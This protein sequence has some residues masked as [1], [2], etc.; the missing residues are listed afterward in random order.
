MG[1]INKAP[2]SQVMVTPEFKVAVGWLDWV[3]S[4]NRELSGSYSNNE[5]EV[6]DNHKVTI[7][8]QLDIS[9]T[10][11][12]VSVDV[13]DGVVSVDNF[14]DSG[15]VATYK[16][17]SNNNVITLPSITDG[18]YVVSGILIRS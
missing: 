11:Y 7:N 5:S 18:Y 12:T 15:H 17:M 4:I 6:V 9:K 16:V 3:N 1:R 2:V 10:S 14:D 13:Y 8:A